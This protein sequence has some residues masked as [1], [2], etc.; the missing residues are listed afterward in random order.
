MNF[1]CQ[2]CSRPFESKVMRRFCSVRCRA[3]APEFRKAILAN[4]KSARANYVPPPKKGETRLCAHCQEPFYLTQTMIKRGAKTCSRVCYRKWMAARF[5]RF[6][7]HIESVDK[8]TGFDEYLSGKTLRCLVVGCEWDGHNLGLHVNMAHGITA[9]ALKESAGF[10]R[11]T[12][13]ISATMAA[14]FQGRST[15]GSE[16]AASHARG[17]IDSSGKRPKVRREGREHQAKAVALWR[18]TKEAT[19]DEHAN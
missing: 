10:N 14:I 4:L 15:A 19:E 9:A 13:L 18:L 16:E 3:S 1:V 5:D 7:G 11:T 6:I 8:V 17:G 2:T 12:G